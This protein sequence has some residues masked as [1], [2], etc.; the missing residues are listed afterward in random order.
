M[1]FLFLF[2]NCTI[3]QYLH[4]RDKE[5]IMI[6]DLYGLIGKTLKH[7]FSAGYFTQKFAQLEMPDAAYVNFEFENTDQIASL[8]DRKEIRGLNVTIP[9]KE[10]VMAHLDDIDTDASIIGAVNTINIRDG[11]WIGYNTDCLGF[12]DTLDTALQ[13]HPHLSRAYILGSGGASKAIQYVLKQKGISYT[14]I[15]RRGD[16]RYDNLQDADLES[17]QLII[18]TTPLGMYPNIETYPDLN[19]QSLSAKHYAIDLIY[20]PEK[21]LFLT[22]CESQGA[23]ILNGHQMLISQAEHSWDIWNLT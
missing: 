16:H 7:S 3:L 11:K 4:K 23:G 13:T 20:N 2:P 6:K 12:G 22:Y 17:T 21:T 5:A 8:K 10:D 15:S 18:N 14:I 1:N 19:Y 9:Y